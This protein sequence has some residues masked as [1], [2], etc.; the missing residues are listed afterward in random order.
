MLIDPQDVFDTLTKAIDRI[1][2]TRDKVAAAAEKLKS[3]E[4]TI[5]T[6]KFDALISEMKQNKA[7]ALADIERTEK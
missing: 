3:E 1:T 7:D 4:F 2:I 6:A 5:A